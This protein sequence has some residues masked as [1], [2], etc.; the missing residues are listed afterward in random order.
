MGS[1][2]D[3]IWD[4]KA[5]EQLRLSC[6]HDENG[7]RI[8]LTTRDEEVAR[9]FKH[10]SDPYFLRFLTVDESCKLLQ[11]KVFHGDICP[12]SYSNSTLLNPN[13]VL[14]CNRKLICRILK[15]SHFNLTKWGSQPIYPLDWAAKRL[16]LLE[17]FSAPITDKDG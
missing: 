5:W 8:V 7:S 14:L 13:I 17:K 2:L 15:N 6:P 12:Q 11:N 10:H 16:Q 3:D 1:V 9:Q 4:V